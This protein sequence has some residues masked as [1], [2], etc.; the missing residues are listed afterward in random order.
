M[1][2]TDKSEYGEKQIKT[3]ELIWGEGFLSPG[4]ID[5]I[6]KVLNGRS[7]KDKRILDIGCG[8]GGAAIHF[9]E[10]LNALHVTGIDIEKKVI[11]RANFLKLKSKFSKKLTFNTLDLSHFINEKDKFDV[12]FSKDAFLHISNKENLCFEVFSLLKSGGFICASDWMRKDDNLPSKQMIEYIQA[13]GLDMQMCSLRR[14]E[15]AL[16]KA[17][18]KNIKLIDRNSWYLKLAKQEI[19]DI[20]GVYKDKLVELIGLKDT[21]E[22]ITVWEKMIGVLEKGEHRPGHFIAD[23]PI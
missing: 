5:E 23:K 8:T 1:S 2:I 4:G 17:G 21:K 11:K 15:K 18:F 3:L 13:E 9:V 22:T 20:Q 19:K 10:N 12:I 16:Y 14:Y 6:N 7:L